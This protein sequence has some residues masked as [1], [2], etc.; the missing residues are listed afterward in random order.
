MVDK[1]LELLEGSKMMLLVIIVKE[2]KGEYVK[3][4]ENFVV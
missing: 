2:C 4:L 3:I 1:V